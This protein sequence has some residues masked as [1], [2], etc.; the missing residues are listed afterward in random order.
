MNITPW[1]QLVIK[2]DISD[3][4]VEWVD[5]PGDDVYLQSE[6]TG[7]LCNI[8][9]KVGIDVSGIRFVLKPKW[10]GSD[11][12][13]EYA[14]DELNMWNHEHKTLWGYIVSNNKFRLCGMGEPLCLYFYKTFVHYAIMAH[15]GTTGSFPMMLKG[16]N[17][18]L[19]DGE[20][21]NWYDS[22]GY[23]NEFLRGN[24]LACFK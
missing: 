20:E 18:G 12:L 19:L 21:R 11:T 23:P 24:L 14:W 17:R 5:L 22:S 9:R 4:H 1:I 10:L 13:D 6:V 16:V 8:V 15:V 7:T 2:N 3:G